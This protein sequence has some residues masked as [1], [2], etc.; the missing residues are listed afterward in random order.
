MLEGETNTL[1]LGKSMSRSLEADA[2]QATS[3]GSDDVPPSPKWR[4]KAHIGSSS[5][6]IGLKFEIRRFSN[7]AARVCDLPA[8]VDGS[9]LDGVQIGRN[10]IHTLYTAEQGREWCTLKHTSINDRQRYK[11]NMQ[12]AVHVQAFI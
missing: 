3:L 9:C 8:P 7:M 5:V 10:V 11:R 4:T 1:T 2:S 6:P 12:Y